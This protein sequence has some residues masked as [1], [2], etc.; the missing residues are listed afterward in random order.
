MNNQLKNME[1][2]ISAE[3]HAIRR[4]KHQS[5]KS[6]LEEMARVSEKSRRYPAPAY[7]VCSHSQRYCEGVD[8]KD[9]DKCYVKK[10]SKSKHATAYRYYKKIA[11]KKLRRANI[12]FQNG[13]YKKNFDYQWSIY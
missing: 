6:R 7:F 2:L 1:C 12:C 9:C 4:Q 8:C 13:D 11:N 10:V 3:Q 5:K